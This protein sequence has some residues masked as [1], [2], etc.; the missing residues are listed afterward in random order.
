MSQIVVQD[1]G[2]HSPTPWDEAILA[3]LVQDFPEDED[4]DEGDCEGNGEL[5]GEGEEE[6]NC[7]EY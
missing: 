3:Q 1:Q 5:D 6:D 2:V 7:G 4:S